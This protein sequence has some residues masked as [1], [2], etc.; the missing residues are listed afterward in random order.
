MIRV[1]LWVLILHLY[2][3]GFIYYLF[4]SYIEGVRKQK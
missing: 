3:E 1:G 4:R 2:R